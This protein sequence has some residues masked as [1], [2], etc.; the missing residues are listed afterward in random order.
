MYS[1][2]AP[3]DI[4][5]RPDI[6]TRVF[7]L[8]QKVDLDQLDNWADA[9]STTK[10]DVGFWRDIVGVESKD[11]Q[12]NGSLFRVLEWGGMEII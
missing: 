7:M 11:Q 4:S 6:V 12:E 8:F 1:K 3:L 9:V 10:E 5:P 2:A